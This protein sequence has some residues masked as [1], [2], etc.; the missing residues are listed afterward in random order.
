MPHTAGDLRQAQAF[1]D[2]TT[3]PWHLEL[4]ST[5]QIPLELSPIAPEL[6]T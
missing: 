3:P 5:K 6:R 4:L 1:A 2:P